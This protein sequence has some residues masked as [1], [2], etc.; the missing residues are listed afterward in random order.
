[1]TRKFLIAPIAA[2]LLAG[3]VA[4][5][6]SV[7]P[8]ELI[9]QGKITAPSCN[10]TPPNGDGIYDFGDIAASSLS[11]SRLPLNPQSKTWTIDCDA[12]TYMTYTADDNEAESKLA[13]GNTN[14][15]L[16]WNG[17]NKIGFYTVT[18][19]NSSVD[20]I[21]TSIYWVGRSDIRVGDG[22][23]TASVY[24][25]TWKLGWKPTSGGSAAALGK[26]FAMD[27]EVAPTLG[28]LT[29]VGSVTQDVPFAGSATLT[30][31]AG[32]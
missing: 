8:S 11:N 15:G 20:G 22:F 31:T 10:V 9:V 4:H 12:D 17:N 32:I 30:F 3:G 5:A 16:G 26:I 6:Q 19:K 27:L 28:N 13:G 29:E 18:M 21:P 24:N 7:N 25:D 23:A 1:M 2:A 14:Y